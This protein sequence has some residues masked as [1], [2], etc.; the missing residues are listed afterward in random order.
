MH[1]LLCGISSLI[2]SVNLIPFTLLLDHLILRISPYHSHH[3]RSRHLSLPQSFTPDLKLVFFITAILHKIR[4]DAIAEFNVDSK[5][6]YT[7]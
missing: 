3:L 4:Y 7:A 1:H 2:H 5:A 6:E